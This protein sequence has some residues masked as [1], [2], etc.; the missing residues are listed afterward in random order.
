MLKKYLLI[1]TALVGTTL[2]ASTAHASYTPTVRTAILDFHGS[3]DFCLDSMREAALQAGFRELD[4]D[5][6]DVEG[7]YKNFSAE[8]ICLEDHRVVVIVSGW[9]A[10]DG[11][12]LRDLLVRTIEGNSSRTVTPI[13]G[14]KEWAPTI[15][16]RILDTNASM[17]E[18]LGDVF[19]A[20]SDAGVRELDVDSN[21]VEG[22]RGY[23]GV[24]TICLGDQ[25]L[26]IASSLDSSD[27]GRLRDR[28]AD[29]LR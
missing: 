4:I 9:S 26:V 12:Q 17:N 20:M 21:D 23:I 2:G 13:S 11:G 1:A 28:I 19:R 3:F 8:I 14:M 15:R 24:E 6:N 27:A 16:T 29:D 25:I 22:W 7:R 18:C 5:S 10:H